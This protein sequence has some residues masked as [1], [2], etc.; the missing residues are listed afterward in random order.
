[1]T[2]VGE[3]LEVLTAPIEILLRDSD[4]ATAELRAIRAASES[5]LKMIRDYVLRDCDLSASCS[6]SQHWA[7]CLRASWRQVAS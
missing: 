7:K 4:K 6:S 1:M 2:T 3:E 5:Q